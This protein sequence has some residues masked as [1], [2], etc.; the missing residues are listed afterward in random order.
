MI[1]AENPMDPRMYNPS[2]S[3]QSPG[4]TNQSPADARTPRSVNSARKLFFD[5]RISATAP[6][7]GAIA[8]PSR[9]APAEA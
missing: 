4:P 3:A 9:S 1:D 7:I 5:A 8:A 6:S 2:A